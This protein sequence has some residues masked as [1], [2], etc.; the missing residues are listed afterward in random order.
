MSLIAAVL[1]ATLNF[2]AVDAEIER[3]MAAGDV[4][5]AAV[6]VVEDG[7]VTHLRGF[8]V[9]NVETKVPVTPETLFRLGSTTKMF[10]ASAAVKVDVN[11]PIGELVT[12]LPPAL[13]AITL[14]QLLTHTAGLRDDAPM[15]GPLEES[16]LEARIRRWDESV[17]FT[18]PGEVMSYSNPGYALAG[19]VIG[20]VAGKP[21]SEAMR[22][23]VLAPAGMLSATFR[24]LEAMTRPLAIGHD[25]KGVIRPFAEHAANYGPGSLF[26]SAEDVGRFLSIIPLERLTARTVPVEGRGIRYGYGVM[27]KEQ[28][29]STMVLHTGARSGYGSIIALL[30]KEKVAVAILANR[31]SAVFGSAA[32]LL[33][34]Q[35]LGKAD[36]TP[37]EGSLP[38]DAEEIR[39]I[40]GTYVNNEIIRVTLVEEGGA[41]VARA[42]GKSL[43][44]TKTGPDRYRLGPG[45]PIEKF[46]IRGKYLFADMHAMLKED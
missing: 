12:D 45:A 34:D 21:F 30:P 41:L 29:G 37:A 14:H 33:L 7:H 1:L 13:G 15:N 44:V 23:Q 3:L 22:E 18:R 16:A 36:A 19:Y 10:V 28:S 20:R 35:V 46:A 6:V 39:R 43:A 31:T 27:V 25:R 26:A 32:A 9:T 8:G 24:P 4:P 40:A 42:G 38:I 11:R 17:F 2:T 5:G